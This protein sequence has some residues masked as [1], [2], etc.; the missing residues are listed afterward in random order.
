M[1]RQDVRADARR[2]PGVGEVVVETTMTIGN[3]ELG[4]EGERHA[5]IEHSAVEV[6][7][8]HRVLRWMLDE[9][10]YLAHQLSV[11]YRHAHRGMF[12]RW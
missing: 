7:R 2:L 6:E 4:A 11:F 12:S 5:L 8:C 3:A 1:S 9:H 10:P